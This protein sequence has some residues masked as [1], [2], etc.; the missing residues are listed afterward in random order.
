M[1]IERMMAG[2]YAANCYFVYEGEKGFIVDPGG[3]VDDIE[4]KLDE[5]GFKPEFILLTH[6]HGDHIAGVS[7]LR[8]KYNIEVY[9]HEEE[10][11]LAAS[12]ELNLSVNM[13]IEKVE[14]I[15]DHTFK[16]GD[17]LFPESYNI[18]VL[19]T[20]GHTRGSVCFKIGNNL[21]S[22]DTVFR[23]TVGRTDLPTSSK[24]DMN[25]SIKNKILPLDDST[26][27][28]PGHGAATTMEF[29]RATNPFFEV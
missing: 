15:A 24:E 12:S 28:H 17:V 5:L 9:I 26:I 19:H 14:I 21:I 6:G 22:G 8:D 2:V 4:R 16:D 11:K 27:I 29:E 1:K 3:D 7:E 18:L 25:N 20:P 13:P 23:G 10:A